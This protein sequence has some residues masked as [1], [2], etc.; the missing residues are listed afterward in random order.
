MKL[1]VQSLGA[2]NRMAHEGAREAAGCLSGLTGVETTVEIAKITFVPAADAQRVRGA[3]DLVGVRVG[4]S[5]ALDGEAVLAFDRESALKVVELLVGQGDATFDESVIR[6]VG[7]IVT[8]GFIDG[9]AD[10]VGKQIDITP[11][12]FVEG[13][14]ETLVEKEKNNGEEDNE[15][16]GNGDHVVAFSSRIETVDG[17]V[18][19]RLFLLLEEVSLEAVLEEPTGQSGEKIAIEKLAG[20]AELT[21]QSAAIVSESLSTMTGIETNVEISELSFVPVEEVPGTV[22]DG[23]RIGIV[24]EFTG[25]P[26]GFVMILF[27]EPSARRLV[28]ALVPSAADEPFDDLGQSAIREIGNVMTSSFVDGWANVLETTIDISTP[29]FVHDLGGAIL[30]PVIVHLGQTQ[31]HVFT[32]DATIEANDDQFDCTIYALPDE[33]ELTSALTALDVERVTDENAKRV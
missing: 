17:D 14:A 25:P 24:V 11:P 4:L 29:R 6:E 10:H 26:S 13:V 16:E 8:S 18:A 27:T 1:D 32:F 23:T 2:F 12:T 30:D 5:G 21:Q 31:E 15:E 22:G 33:V 20:F 7:N 9:W 19:F 28:S 3:T